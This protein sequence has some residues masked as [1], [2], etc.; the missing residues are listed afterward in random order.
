[1]ARIVPAGI[2]G[3]NAAAEVGKT[4]CGALGQAAHFGLDG[5]VAEVGAPGDAQAAQGGQRIGDGG[6]VVLGLV[7]DGGGVTRIGPGGGAGEEGGVGDGAGDGAVVGAGGPDVEVGPVGYASERGLEAEDA[8]EG[9]GDADGAGAVGAVGEGAESGGHGRGGAAA[10][11]ARGAISV[12]GIAAR[13]AELV[14]AHVLVAEVGR[15]GL[16]DDDG[17]GGL[18]AAGDGAVVAGDLVGV[19]DRAV[20]VA[21]TGAG[22]KVFDGDGQTVQEAEVVAAHDGGF[23]GASDVEGAVAVDGQ[24]GVDGGVDALDAV[25]HGLD[26]FN[27]GEAFGAHGGGEFGGGRA[28]QFGRGHLCVPLLVTREMS[29]CCRFDW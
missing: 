4:P 13:I 8:A 23:G 19:E 10:G 6:E 3:L 11:A 28:A 17:A 2:D 15:I 16:A 26:Q 1:M 24:I 18:D 12:P 9:G 22:F 20:G 5:G 14:V 7:V 29:G 27:R 21:Q 25:Q